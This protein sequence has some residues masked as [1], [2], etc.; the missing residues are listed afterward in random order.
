MFCPWMGHRLNPWALV[1]GLLGDT[2]QCDPGAGQVVVP[3]SQS[4]LSLGPV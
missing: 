3:T 2:S 4:D 1:F